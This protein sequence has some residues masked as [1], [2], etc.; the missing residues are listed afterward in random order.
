MATRK[1]L[2]VPVL[3]ASLLLAACEEK[4][5]V[6]E[7]V[8]PVRAMKVQD[9]DGFVQRFFPG[10]ATATQEI[11][12]AFRVS[13]QLIE[14]PIEIGDE[15]G[16]GELVAALDPSTFQTEVDR[17]EAEVASSRAVLERAVLE[18][19]RQETLFE[20][21]GSRR[22]VSTRYARTSRRRAPA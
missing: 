8:R 3:F 5:E 2:I 7:V 10:R 13:G 20:R 11:N 6:V 21:V 19:D 15:I 4:Q 22:P 9:V 1:R 16:K 17:S 14:R 12:A 18:L